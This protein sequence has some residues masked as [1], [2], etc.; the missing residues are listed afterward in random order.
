MHLQLFYKAHTTYSK[1][2]NL[3]QAPYPTSIV[4]TEVIHRGDIEK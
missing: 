2:D 4:L 3:G 1:M